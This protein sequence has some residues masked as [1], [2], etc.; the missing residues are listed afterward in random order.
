M[1]RIVALFFCVIIV[2]Y[3]A[4]SFYFYQKTSTMVLSAGVGAFISIYKEV[5]FRA[6][7]YLKL[8][9]V[10]L[11]VFIVIISNYNFMLDMIHFIKN[12]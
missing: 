11:L 10:F 12:L 6:Y 2:I 1:N 9:F 4:I 5:D 8:P 3:G 7:D